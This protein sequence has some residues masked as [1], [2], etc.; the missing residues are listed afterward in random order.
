MQ[1]IPR[2]LSVG[3]VPARHTGMKSSYFSGGDMPQCGIVGMKKGILT[4][5]VE[6]RKE[7]A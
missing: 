4:L 5:A 1:P 6:S 2:E 3:G 7:R